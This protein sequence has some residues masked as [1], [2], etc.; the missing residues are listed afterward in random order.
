MVNRTAKQFGT[1]IKPTIIIII[2][3]PST[4]RPDP[5]WD[6]GPHSGA[7]CR[8][9]PSCHQTLGLAKRSASVAISGRTHSYRRGTT[10]YFGSTSLGV[11]PGEPGNEVTGP[12]QRRHSLYRYAGGLLLHEFI[13]SRFNHRPERLRALSRRFQQRKETRLVL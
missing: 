10:C 3:W 1:F 4:P 13:V 11:C 2:W 6:H 7:S 8:F 5:Q 12:S 9:T